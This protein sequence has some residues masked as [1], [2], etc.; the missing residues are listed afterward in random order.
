MNHIACGGLSNLPNIDESGLFTNMSSVA[1]A[2]APSLAIMLQAVLL[3]LEIKPPI[4]DHSIQ[5]YINRPFTF[6]FI[7]Y[8]LKFTE[9][10][11]MSFDHITK[12]CPCNIQKFLNS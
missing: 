4:K 1:A 10:K 8:F 3:A 2:G 12:T 11:I 5:Q 9:K 6:S 7:F